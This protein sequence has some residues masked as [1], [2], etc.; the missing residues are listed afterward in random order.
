M[1]ASATMGTA[2]T[3]MDSI[4]SASAVSGSMSASASM[5]AA[6]R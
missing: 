4:S 6:S 2:S 5:Q 1:S 3:P